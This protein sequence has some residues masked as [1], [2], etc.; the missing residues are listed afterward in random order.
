VSA[1]E[2][3]DLPVGT[4]VGAYDP[5]RVHGGI[6][7]VFWTY[8]HESYG[9]AGVGGSTATPG[10]IAARPNLTIIYTPVGDE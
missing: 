4:V 10:E 8:R 6:R 5:T 7:G 3:A 9:W 1:V 2:V